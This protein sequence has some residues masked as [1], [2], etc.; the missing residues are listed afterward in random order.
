MKSKRPLYR[1]YCLLCIDSYYCDYSDKEECQ[2]LQTVR[3]LCNH[4]RDYYARLKKMLLSLESVI[5]EE[6]A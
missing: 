4:D 1:K 3:W 6:F 2:T 5:K